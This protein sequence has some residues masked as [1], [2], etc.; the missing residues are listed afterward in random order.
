MGIQQTTTAMGLYIRT[1]DCLPSILPF[2]FKQYQQHYM[3]STKTDQ[4]R[5][6]LDIFSKIS[7]VTIPLLTM[8]YLN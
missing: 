6:L 3:R 4:L 7:I 1:V 5:T 8:A 2:F